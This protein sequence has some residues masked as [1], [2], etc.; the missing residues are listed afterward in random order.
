MLGFDIF[1]D[2]KSKAWLLEVNQS[3]SFTT[4]TPLDFNI[5]K[6]LISDA[7]AMLNL[8]WK[9]KNKYIQQKRLEQQK[10]VLVGKQ[11]MNLDEKESIREKKMK[12]KDKFEQANLGGYEL[13]YPIKRGVTPED[14]QLM[15]KY[16]F[17][18]AK[19][20]EIWEESIAGGG[21]KKKVQDPES[22][23]A[24]NKP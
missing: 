16:E 6:N 12:V 22:T 3:P 10:R 21:Y 14:D 13:L 20:K 17:L 23:P 4:D 19:S 18:L 5:K 9:R 2:N 1:I 8:N 7:I 24:A 15:D 11:K